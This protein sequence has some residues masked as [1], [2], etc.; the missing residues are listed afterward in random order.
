MRDRLKEIRRTLRLPVSRLLAFRRLA[1]Y[2][3]RPRTLEDTVE[4]AM[5]FGRYG[6]LTVQ[7][8]QVRSEITALARA[9]AA[10]E[11]RI[12]LEIGTA[13]GGTLLIWSRLAARKVVSCDLLHHPARKRLLEALPPPGSRCEVKLLTGDSHDPDFRRRVEAELGGDLADFLFIDGD[14]TEAGVAADFR[15]Y[16]GFVRPGGLIA[17]HDILD[18]QPLDTNQVHRFWRAIRD[19]YPSQEFI[20]DRSQC[21]FGIGVIQASPRDSSS[22]ARSRDA[23]TTGSSSG[24][25]GRDE[26]S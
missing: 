20:A 2:H 14:H 21:G 4:W 8:M 6:H 1:Q 9:V 13:K 26:N 19:C 7:T 10:L 17:F 22:A 16:S 15:D 25:L 11:P 3:A 23:A 24:G 5:N 12:I 18:N